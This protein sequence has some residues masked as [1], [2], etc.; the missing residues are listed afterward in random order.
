MK[1]LTASGAAMRALYHLGVLLVIEE[2][3]GVT[4]PG[5]GFDGQVEGA[6]I[7]AQRV[8][9][10][11]FR[12]LVRLRS[13]LS[14]AVPHL[15]VVHHRLSLGCIQARALAANREACLTQVVGQGELRLLVV[16]DLVCWQRASRPVEHAS[17]SS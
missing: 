17:S 16:S 13:E 1:V 5:G 14:E 7:R 4:Q 6:R 12:S 15:Q 2:A 9:A 11:V 10:I 3:V 8:S